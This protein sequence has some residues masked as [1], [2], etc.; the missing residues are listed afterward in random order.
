MESQEAYSD[1][2]GALLNLRAGNRVTRGGWNGKGMFIE[3]V[4][5]DG[6]MY[7]DGKMLPY[8]VMKTAQGEYVPWLASQTDLL[9]GDWCI[10][11]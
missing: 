6:Q 11:I 4:N 3:L 10:T 7:K 1:F 5:N 8:I 9:A 2:G